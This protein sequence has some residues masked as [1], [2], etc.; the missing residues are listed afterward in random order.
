M[1]AN[2]GKC[3]PIIT[4]SLYW[5]GTVDSRFQA[6]VKS[7]CFKAEFRLC[8]AGVQTPS[9]LAVGFGRVPDNF[10]GKTGQAGNLFHE[11]FNGYLK[12]C[13]DIDRLVFVVLFSRQ[14]NPLGRIRGIDKLPAG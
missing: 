5:P 6:F 4:I 13:P 9:R 12:T 2:F 7:V 10:T 11:I 14:D 3:V 1:R 8:P